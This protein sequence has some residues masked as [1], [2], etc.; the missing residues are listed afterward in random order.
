MSAG[1]RT[2]RQRGRLHDGP[3]GANAHAGDAV[4]K[5]AKRVATLHTYPMAELPAIK[6]RLIQQGVDVIDVGAG[7]ADFPPP[8]VAAGAVPKALPESSM[9]RYSSQNRPPALR[10]AASATRLP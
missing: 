4:T 6:R 9:S 8:P 5:L 7:D 3:P 2:R 10:A 1:E